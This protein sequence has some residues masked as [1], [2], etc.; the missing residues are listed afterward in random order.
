MDR[1][2]WYC[3]RLIESHCALH[4]INFKTDVRN[5]VSLSPEGELNSDMCSAQN[6]GAHGGSTVA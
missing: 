5:A 4:G 2:E 1:I 6:C 3:C